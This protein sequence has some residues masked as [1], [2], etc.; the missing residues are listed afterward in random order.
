MIQKNKWM[1]I[2][3]SLLILLPMLVGLSMW[4]AL[5]EQLPMH[6]NAAGEIDG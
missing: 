4:K 5:P 1:L 6:W 2:I 3:G